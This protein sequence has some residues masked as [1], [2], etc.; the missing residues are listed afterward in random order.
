MNEPMTSNLDPVWELPLTRQELY[1]Y[2]QLLTS[3][4][5]MPSPDAVAAV[6]QKMIYRLARVGAVKIGTDGTVSIP[7]AQEL[8]QLVG[9]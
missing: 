4:D 2:L 8:R 3:Q 7:T 6:G 9:A 1:A 5:G